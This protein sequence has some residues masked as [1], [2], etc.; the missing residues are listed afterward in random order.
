MKQTLAMLKASIGA[1]TWRRLSRGEYSLQ[2]KVVIVTGASSGIGAVLVKALAAEGARV[3]LVARRESLL[4]EVASGLKSALIIPADISRDEDQVR[5]VDTV[6]QQYGRIDVLI[7][8]AG[9]ARGGAV[10]E[11]E[12]G[13]VRRMVDI[14]L[15]G[16]IRLTQLVLPGMLQRDSGQIVNISSVAG[17]VRAPGQSV[18]AATKAAVNG[19]GD[20]LRREL[21]GTGVHVISI[22]PGWVRTPMVA[23]GSEDDLH[24]A[25]LLNPF[26]KMDEPE[27]VVRKT[28]N[29]I[30][31]YKRQ[32]TMG[33]VGFQVGIPFARILPRFAD[34]NYRFFL[35]KDKLIQAMRKTLQ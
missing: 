14:N 9:V 31:F 22:L 21:V 8:N 24:N 10:T 13:D 1:L 2:G 7:N 28:M 20:A 15:Y 6:M 30:K 12:G 16:L 17:E 25:R 23:D 3:V 34:L 19:F 11:I 18:Y 33:G 27:V 32:V 26:F 4:Q 5:I 29:A 35:K